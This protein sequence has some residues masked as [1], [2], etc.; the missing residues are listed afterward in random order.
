[1]RRGPRTIT[2]KL[3]NCRDCRRNTAILGEYYSVNNDVWREGGLAPDGGLLCVKCLEG[4][5]GRTLRPGDFVSC[6]VNE[7]PTRYR[8]D[9]LCSRLGMGGDPLLA[10]IR[11]SLDDGGALLEALTR[12]LESEAGA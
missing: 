6:R 5:L 1:M 4:R 11:D 10:L 8:S 12:D 9:L 3:W 2:S 7:D